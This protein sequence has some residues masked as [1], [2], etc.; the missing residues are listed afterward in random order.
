MDV[1]LVA[2]AVRAGGGEL[3]GLVESERRER[4]MGATVMVPERSHEQRMEALRVANAVRFGMRDVK[5][6]VG[7]MATDDGLREIAD[8]LEHA[9]AMVMPMAI[10]D[11]LGAPRRVGRVSVHGW[12]NVAGVRSADRRVRDLSERQRL[13]LARLLRE[14]AR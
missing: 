5:R 13:L 1:G 11:L 8:R 6:R 2:G 9:D 3:T 10:G 7:R 4:V 12:L 14:R